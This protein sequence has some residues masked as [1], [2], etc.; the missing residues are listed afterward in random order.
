MDTKSPSP[1]TKH[2][3]ITDALLTEIQGGRYKLGDLLPSEP[4]LSQR[5]GVSRH[6]IRAALRSLQELGLVAG[7]KGIGTR[8]KQTRPVSRYS[9]G[10]SSAEDLLQYATTTQVRVLDKTEVAVDKAMAER[11]GCKAGEHWWRVRTA[12]KDPVTNAVVAYSEIYI[13]LAFGAALQGLSRSRQPIFSLIV[14]RFGVTIS[15]IRQEI[16]CIAS[17]TKEEAQFLQVPEG[18]PAMQITRHYFGKNGQVMEVARSL[19]PNEVFKYAMRVQLHHG[20]T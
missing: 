6:T 15:E 4:E 20:E 14:Q 18:S 10:F 7:E 1:T 8:V 12:R 13:P 9:H 16:S 17:V 2:G 3:L 5:F 19:H 11:F